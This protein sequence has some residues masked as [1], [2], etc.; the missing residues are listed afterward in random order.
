MATGSLRPVGQYGHWTSTATG[1]Y[2]HLVNT[3]YDHWTSTATGPVRTLDQY[4]HW[5]ART[6]NSIVACEKT[7][8]GSLIA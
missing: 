7:P 4:S 6:K 1:S 8:Q 3:Q 2:N 5:S